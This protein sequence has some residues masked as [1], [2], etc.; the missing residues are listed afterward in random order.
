MGSTLHTALPWIPLGSAVLPPHGAFELQA[1]V[2]D[3]GASVQGLALRLQT[4]GLST[5]SAF[6]LGEPATIVLLDAGL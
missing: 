6:H 4:V 2:P 1:Q 3:L 5:S